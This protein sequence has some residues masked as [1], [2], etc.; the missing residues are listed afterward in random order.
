LKRFSLLDLWRGSADAWADLGSVF[1]ESAR[2][3]RS[4]RR[5]MMDWLFSTPEWVHGD[6]EARMRLYAWR[7][8]TLVTLSFPLLLVAFFE[9]LY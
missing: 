9:V 7:T 8:S 5:L 4:S 6:W 1:G 2:R 3:N